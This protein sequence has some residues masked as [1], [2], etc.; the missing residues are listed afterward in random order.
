MSSQESDK[1]TS[2]E[3]KDYGFPFVEVT[4]LALVNPKKE[5]EIEKTSGAEATAVAA[6]AIKPSVGKGLINPTMA[7]H[8]RPKKQSPVLL[9]LV[10][11]IVVI[12]GVMAY[13]LYYMP[14]TEDA[15]FEQ[16]AAIENTMPLAVEST[17]PEVVE[18]A[19][20]LVIEDS[21]P[22][23]SGEE[24]ITPISAPA[25]SSG[26]SVGN[27]VVIS[28]PGE[29]P[30]YHIIVG[31]VPSEKLAKEEADKQLQK[32]KDIY[33]LS[34]HGETKNYR[35]SVGSYNTFR[36]ASQA[37]EEAK[38]EFDESIWILKY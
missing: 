17:S 5:A 32:G 19:E 15:G 6:G 31:S 3:D 7:S 25:T 9:S 18:E 1:N 14:S 30:L 24:A 33:L 28:S 34:P 22:E 37:L 29:R 21:E 11:L 26:N 10:L 8:K 35:L 2:A 23:E 27:L 12:L 13:F 36:E 38:P 4:P 20:E 16:S